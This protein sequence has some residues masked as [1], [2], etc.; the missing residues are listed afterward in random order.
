MP[1]S[2]TNNN[3]KVVA[4]TTQWHVL[5]EGEDLFCE[6]AFVI[7]I[8][9]ESGGEFVTVQSNIEE[10]YG[11]GEGLISINPEEWPLLRDTIDVAI[12]ACKPQPK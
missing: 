8:V 11:R 2:K 10:A 3:Q 5:P 9:D 12:K 4:R 7:N 6:Q 1:S